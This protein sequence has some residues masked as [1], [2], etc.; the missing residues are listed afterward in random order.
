[1]PSS[2]TS[3]GASPTRS[4]GR[5]DVVPRKPPPGIPP[6]KRDRPLEGPENEWVRDRKDSHDRWA[7]A[8]GLIVK[9]VA[10]VM[11]GAALLT[12]GQQVGAMFGWWA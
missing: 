11:G 3:S 8:R 2:A 1:L 10:F 7:W 12:V 9:T 5:P 4:H 6:P